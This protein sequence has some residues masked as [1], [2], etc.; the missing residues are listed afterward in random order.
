MK[1]CY[2]ILAALA[3][4]SACQPQTPGQ[5]EAANDSAAINTA[6]QPGI[7]ATFYKRLKGTLA[8][9][10]VTMHL[11]RTG[12]ASFDAWYAYDKQGIPIQ[13]LQQ[14]DDTTGL[15]F[16]EY[17]TP[18]ANCTF[19][20]SLSSGGDYKGSWTGNGK[21][22]D[23]D[24]KTDNT[25]ALLFDVYAGTDSVLLLPANPKSPMGM[26]TA[27]LVWPSGGADEAALRAVK[28][29]L[30]PANLSEP[31]EK[32]VRQSIDTFLRDYKAVPSNW[33]KGD[34]NHY[35][36]PHCGAHTFSR[37]YLD[38]MGGNFWAVNVACLDDA[39]EEELG[40]APIV[41]EDGKHDR[42]LEPPVITSYL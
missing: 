6:A 25:G 11:I 27:T 21:T 17:T 38:F 42:Q 9:Q 7:A 37:D 19:S 15:S 13:L 33:P 5:Q 1:V 29:A 39:S 4:F 30:A 18:D 35:M 24:L 23:F 3:L 32:L 10:P 20:G 12:P 28:K 14:T 34:I 8:G 41:Y 40:A 2:G 36:C 31:P 22:Y 16:S 26:A